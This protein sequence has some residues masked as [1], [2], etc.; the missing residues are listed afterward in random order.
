MTNKLDISYERQ[1]VAISLR[2]DS[3]IR[4]NIKQMIVIVAACLSG[5][6]ASGIAWMKIQNHVTDENHPT[7]RQI[8]DLQLRV[9]LLEEKL[10]SLNR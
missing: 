7:S 1:P 6:F 8:S 4:L 2:P 10:K 3:T 9:S 5:A